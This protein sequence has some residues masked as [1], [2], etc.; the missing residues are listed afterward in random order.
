MKTNTHSNT[1]KIKA[2]TLIELLV[3]IAII[4]ILAAI[5]F[6]VFARARENARRTSCL[7]NLKQQG[8][9]VM[10][11][12]QDYD[13]QL[14]MNAATGIGEQPDKPWQND[15]LA[16]WFWPQFLYPYTK[17]MQ[18]AYCPSSTSTY[19]SSSPLY[20]NYGANRNVIGQ[21][22]AYSLAT[23]GAPANTYMLMDSGNILMYPEMAISS[24]S[25]FYYVPGQGDAG[26]NCTSTAADT[27]GNALP[28]CKSGRHFNGVNIA[29]VDGHVKWL[30]TQ[31]VV[32]EARKCTTSACTA[33]QSAWSLALGGI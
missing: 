2:F 33:N 28:D 27:A 11:Y 32:A 18:V 31:T 12:T 16:K 3:V 15:N 8:L 19:N 5:L 17:S 13:E 20:I 23:A 1:T 22:R 29:F 21:S 4:S 7:S 14:P 6:P 10:M 30:K 25:W 24:D 9:A 26:S